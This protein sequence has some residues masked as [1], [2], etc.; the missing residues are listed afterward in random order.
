MINAR[1]VAFLILKDISLKSSYTDIALHRGL[2]KFRLSPQDRSLVTELVYGIIRRRRTLDNLIK[3]FGKKEPHKQ[4]AGLR[5]ILYLGFYQLRYMGGIPVSAAVNTCVDLAKQENYGKLSGVVNGILR[6][7][8]RVKESGCD[9]LELPKDNIANLGILHS[10]PD[11]IIEMFLRQFGLSQT[12]ELCLWFN[13]TPN[14]DIRINTLKTTREEVEKIFADGDIKTE[15]LSD[16]ELGLRLIGSYGAVTQLPGYYEGLW[17]VQDAGAQGISYL[18]DPKSGETIADACAA[19]GGK[20][21]HIAELMKDQGQIWAIDRTESRLKRLEENIKRLEINS[22]NM[23]VG[24][25][26]FLDKFNGTCDRILLDVPCS[27]LGTLHRHPD[28]RWQMNK[29]KIN[30]IR[31]LQKEILDSTHRWLKPKGILVYSTCTLNPE[32]NEEIIREF[33]DNHFEYCQIQVTTIVPHQH[34]QDGFF[35]AKLLKQ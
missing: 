10:F 5:L 24:D 17:T 21:T 2:Q 7:Y 16:N 3:Q 30:E 11:W 35:M 14:L 13:Q 20:T 29:E 33:L 12:E 32:E 27:G 9:P 31:Q 26:R 23:Q 18:L 4:P 22:I 6:Q 25:C 34:N 19:P 28:I 1:Y 15:K 8:V